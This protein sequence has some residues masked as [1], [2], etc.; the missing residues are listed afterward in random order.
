MAVAEIEVRAIIQTSLA[1]LSTQIATAEQY[2]A[3]AF[4]A[5]DPP[6]AP[7]AEP[8]ATT[9]QTWIA[10]HFCAITD[11][12]LDR[13][14]R[15]QAQNEYQDSGR[16][17]GLLYTPWGQTACVLDPTGV[18]AKSDPTACMAKCTGGGETGKA[19]EPTPAVMTFF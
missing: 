7:P 17:M 19:S 4:A 11:P 18:L 3:A 10:A 6:V 2:F 13:T 8:L 16:A 12:R 9:I 5:T 15:A 14:Q 1:E